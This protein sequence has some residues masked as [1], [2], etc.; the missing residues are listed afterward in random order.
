MAVYL[1]RCGDSGMVKIGFADDPERRCRELQTAHWE[2]L[3]L[4]RVIEGDI[5]AET[6]MHGRFS[7]FRVRGEWFRLTEEMLTIKI[8]KPEPEPPPRLALSDEDRAFISEIAGRMGPEKVAALAAWARL[9]TSGCQDR[10]QLGEAFVSAL[11]LPD[12]PITSPPSPPP[13]A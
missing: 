12:R 9:V 10:S 3:S 6:W 7:E 2:P 4:I 11:N 5:G 8:E 1:I 13:A